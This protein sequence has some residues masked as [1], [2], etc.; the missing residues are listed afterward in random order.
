MFI[1]LMQL[2]LLF[3]SSSV[4]MISGLLD[5]IGLLGLRI[6]KSESVSLRQNQNCLMFCRQWPLRPILS[7]PL[8]CL[9]VVNTLYIVNIVNFITD[10]I[11]SSYGL[12]VSRLGSCLRYCTLE[13]S[14]FFLT[15][16]VM[17][18]VFIIIYSNKLYF[19]FIPFFV[20]MPNPFS[21]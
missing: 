14:Q 17:N 21:N 6:D 15:G 5:L 8:T 1:L 19:V 20:N 12:L 7:Q 13:F 16:K 10:M 9:G 18:A 2:S 11:V 4:R 3:P